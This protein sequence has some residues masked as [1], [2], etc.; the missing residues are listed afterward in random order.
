[1]ITYEMASKDILE[2]LYSVHYQFTME[3]KKNF[4]KIRKIDLSSNK[5]VIVLSYI[6][7]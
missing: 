2:W 3:T 6:D 7:A 5:L 4:V 1:M